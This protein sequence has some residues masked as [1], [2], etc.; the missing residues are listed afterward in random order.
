MAGSPQS[1][2]PE[3]TASNQMEKQSAPNKLGVQAN[4]KKQW[5][6]P[7]TP[8]WMNESQDWVSD[9]ARRLF[10]TLRGMADHNTGELRIPDRGWI[11]LATVERKS[12][13]KKRSRIA[14]MKELV[15]LRWLK[16]HRPY[17]H[18]TIRGSNL[19]VRSQ[20]QLTVIPMSELPHEHSIFPKL[21]CKK[22]HKQRAGPTEQN[23]KTK[24]SPIL[25]SARP[26]EQ[27]SEPG[28]TVQIC[29]LGPIVQICTVKDSNYTQASAPAVSP[30]P[31]ASEDLDPKEQT[32]GHQKA[33]T[34]KAK[35][36]TVSYHEIPT[37]LSPQHQSLVE[38]MRA[39][40]FAKIERTWN[41][42]DRNLAPTHTHYRAKANQEGLPWTIFCK[43]F[44]H[45]VSNAEYLLTPTPLVINKPVGPVDAK[46]LAELA[47]ADPH[48]KEHFM[49]DGIAVMVYEDGI[50]EISPGDREPKWHARLHA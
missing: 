50:Q 46:K 24:K 10:L 25:A 34:A 36:P 29:T 38:S 22:P 15:K 7:D 3:K 17:V 31:S 9:D 19:L 4:N 33:P 13:L 43:E 16:V 6:V 18:M 48:C 8:Q 26:T 41:T 23:S 1:F 2:R 47:A 39:D 5:V 40:V 49:K 45:A 20:T 27:N 12:S 11:S 37:T 42:N 28:P 32:Q 21:P 30:S 14:A 35:S 44:E